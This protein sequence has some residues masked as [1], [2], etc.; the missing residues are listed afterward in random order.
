MKISSADV[1][2]G[3]WDVY[4]NMELSDSDGPTIWFPSTV[5]MI[6]DC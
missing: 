6:C 5:K 2:G 1:M 4:L 3:I